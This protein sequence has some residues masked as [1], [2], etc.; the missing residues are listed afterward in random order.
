MRPS[1][2]PDSRFARVHTLA[3]DLDRS[4]AAASAAARPADA[5]FDLKLA[6]GLV[7][8]GDYAA[9]RT[10]ARRLAHMPSGGGDLLADIEC[11]R[12]IIDDLSRAALNPASPRVLG[13][14]LKRASAEARELAHALELAHQALANDTEEC[15]VAGHAVAPLAARL[16][17][18]VT[19]TLPIEARVRYSEEFMSELLEIARTGGGRGAQFAYVIRQVTWSWRLHTAVRASRRHQAD[20]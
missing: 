19:W 2:H 13:L 16:L 9:I 7:S 17:V 1:Q 4:L 6:F 5:H 15:Q 20:L 12:K 18:P 11:A 8:A 3:V 10:R 14:H